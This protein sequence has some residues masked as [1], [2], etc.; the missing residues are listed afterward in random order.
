MK[1]NIFQ[2][3]YMTGFV[4]ISFAFQNCKHRTEPVPPPS[5]PCDTA[6]VPT[7][8]FKI[9]EAVDTDYMLDELVPYW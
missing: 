8:D 7:A 6:K 4:L 9:Y 2:I 1:K 3:L 5:N